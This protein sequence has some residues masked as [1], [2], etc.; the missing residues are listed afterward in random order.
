M[1]I[2]MGTTPVES[3]VAAGNIFVGQVSWSMEKHTSIGLL[4]IVKYGCSAS[5]CV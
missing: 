3:F 5:I 2:F 1:H 4:I